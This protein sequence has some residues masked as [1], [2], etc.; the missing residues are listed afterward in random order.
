MVKPVLQA[1]LLA[2]HVYSDSGTGKKI[3]AGIFDR[4]IFKKPDAE[5]T[6]ISEAGRISIQVPHAGYQA[7]S[8]FCYI[9]LTEVRG[10]QPFKLRY[11]DLAEDKAVL[12]TEFQVD[13][14]DPL[15]T[16]EIALPLPPLPANKPGVFA[17]ELLWNEEPL[18]SHRIII[19]EMQAGEPTNE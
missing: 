12:Q 4:L 14:P 13:C 16:V 2:D 6:E 8:P 18:G 17:L 19:E 3:I 9:S 5:Q 7:S 1:L 15:K 10:K 11:V